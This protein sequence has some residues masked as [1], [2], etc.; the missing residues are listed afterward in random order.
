MKRLE[1]KNSVEV[2]E[3]IK[4]TPDKL[5]DEK[6]RNEMEQLNQELLE[7]EKIRLG[8]FELTNDAI[9]ILDLDGTYRDVNQKAAE[10]LGYNRHD[11]I[12]KSMIEFVVEDEKENSKSRLKDLIDG[13]ILPIY[14]RKFKRRDGSV[15]IAEINAAV[16]QDTNGAPEY[17]QSAVRDISERVEAEEALKRERLAYHLIA[18]VTIYSQNL[19]ELSL[20]LIEGLASIL[21]FDAATFRLYDAETR[22]LIPVAQINFLTNDYKVHVEPQSIDDLDYLFSFVAKNK[23]AVV[24]PNF[25]D[26]AI[27]APY[28]EKMKEMGIYSILTWPILDGSNEILGVLQLVSYKPKEVPKEDMIFFETMA[29]MFTVA[30]ERKRAE[31]A[32][33]E[34]EEKYRSFAYNFQGIAFR[35]KPDWIPIFYNGAV[36]E[37]TGYTETE[38][39]AEKPRCSDIIHPDDKEMVS[40]YEKEL[41]TKPNNIYEIQYRILRKD[42]QIKWLNEIC[43]NV[44]DEKSDPQYIQGAIYDISER[45]RT[46]TLQAILKDLAIALS[47]TS[48]I[49]NAMTVVLESVINMEVVECGSIFLI[50]KESGFL[51]PIINRGFTDEFLEKISFYSTESPFTKAILTGKSNYCDY[52]EIVSSPFQTIIQDEEGLHALAVIPV[53]SEGH[54]EAILCLGS[55]KSDTIPM[56]TRNALEMIAVQIAGSISRIGAEEALRE[57]NKKYK[58]FVENF[59]GIAYRM[60]TDGKPVFLDGAVEEITGFTVNE[61]ILENDPRKVLTH[62]YDIDD[63]KKAIE[64]SLTTHEASKFEYRIITKDGQIRWVQDIW[65]ALLNDQ[66]NI[67]GIQ[68]SI[69]NITDRKIAQNEIE[70]LYQDL[71]QRVE[72][73]TEQLT[74]MNKELTAFSYSVS[75]DLRTPLRH[76]GG[77]ADLLQKRVSQNSNVDERILSYTQKI[78][79][80]VE[81][82]NKLI[83]GLLTFSR[84]SRVEMVNIKINLNELI[85]D[86]LNDFQ[87]ELENRQVDIGVNFLPDVQGDPSLL[88][89]V[90]VNLIT[91]ALKFTKTRDITEITIGTKPSKEQDKITIYISDNG[92]GF[93]MQY[94]DKLFGVFQRLHKSEEFEGT[95]IGLATVQRVIRRMGG[96]IWAEG[97]VD[98][99][100]TFYFSIPVAAEEKNSEESTE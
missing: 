5:T 20:R 67:I 80:S 66:G 52:N 41:I 69:H 2:K 100:A 30:L 78:L 49:S 96:T 3:K 70:T 8:L 33:K 18:E 60:T 45:K 11:M 16:V 26:R 84:M 9:F 7:S 22:M 27:M 63:L 99:G 54:I 21:D 61:L 36:K 68:G 62:P 88:R 72:E 76:I 75:H 38:L 14:R 51:N 89:L 46:E 87:V 13:R 92:V 50:D 77:F 91:N 86:V 93:D 44:C 24:A 82:M 55:R 1:K 6:L 74:A 94:Y 64:R 23:R 35:A 71:E 73:R 58:T 65:Q 90:L 34:S 98:K 4:D 10:I 15:F 48:F 31:E 47:S 97:E 17:I 95:G 43:Q 40:R 29:R 25:E 37:I 39:L 59:Q 53:L 79:S 19:A 81:E 32:L 12:G 42:G 85:Q 83:D 56:N 28:Q 57:S